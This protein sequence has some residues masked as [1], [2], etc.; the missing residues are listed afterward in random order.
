M[1]KKLL[2]QYHAGRFWP[3]IIPIRGDVIFLHES[4]HIHI[5]GGNRNTV[6]GHEI[7]TSVNSLQHWT[8][9]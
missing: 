6:P 3:D 2:P 9:R 7:A 8:M 1:W 4:R 5:A